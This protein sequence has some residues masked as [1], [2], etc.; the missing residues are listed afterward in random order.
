MAD[1]FPPDDPNSVAKLGGDLVALG[2]NSTPY[3]TLRVLLRDRGCQ[4]GLHRHAETLEQ[5]PAEAGVI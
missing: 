3:V 4:H 1:T 5:S 2:G